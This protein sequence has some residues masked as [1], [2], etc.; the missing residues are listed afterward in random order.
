MTPRQGV[1]LL[2]VAVGAS[3]SPTS[4]LGENLRIQR[5]SWSVD[6][7][8]RDNPGDQSAVVFETTIEVPGAAWIR[9]WFGDVHL[10][11]GSVIVLTSQVDSS[12][13]V[14]D[15]V[16]V[17]Q[18]RGGSAY[19]NGESVCVELWAG[20]YTKGNSV[21]IDTVQARKLSGRGVESSQCGWTDDRWPSANSAIAR[22]LN[23][24]GSPCTAALVGA[25]G[26]LL[27]AGHCFA[28]PES[29]VVA[30]FNV[31]P[32]LPDGTLV[33]PPASEQYAIDPSSVQISDAGLGYDWAY[34][35]CF[36]NP[37]TGLTPA[38]AQ[39]SPL[40][41]AE[42]LPDVLPVTV[43]VTG[44]GIDTGTAN[45]TQQSDRG[46]LHDI[47]TSPVHLQYEVDT[48]A[49]NS[50]SPVTLECT[51]EVVGVHTHN[52]C[53]P[54][55]PPYNRG[56]PITEPALQ[57]AMATPL[58]VCADMLL[59]DFDGDGVPNDQDNCQLTPNGPD[60]GSCVAGSKGTCLADEDCDTRSG[61]GDGLCSLNQ[62]DSDQD[63]VGD[64]CDNCALFNPG[65][66]DCQPNG[67]GD[68]CDIADGT[69]SD[70]DGDCVPDECACAPVAD[71]DCDGDVDAFDLALLLGSWGPCPEPCEPGDPATT[72]PADLDGDCDV[73]AFDS[74]LL[75]GNWGP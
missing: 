57:A 59:E 55:P 18:W 34:F 24:D 20:P 38:Q 70:D 13:Q 69:S 67:I 8:P 14:L 11:P 64:A 25:A 39:G 7:G 15:A 12:Y 61:S 29:V 47:P 28:S 9:L 32:S 54:N 40:R 30:E 46:P 52:G 36:P 42:S 63:G 41:A 48:Q 4:A 73:G 10:G 53:V 27:S 68:V 74:A 3:L 65:Q 16:A 44:Y 51:A 2:I 17:G 72:C 37:V 56:T 31:P 23:V 19:F 66:L 35:G 1:L 62:E 6:S 43:V 45:S 75:L 33:H 60:L 50:G 26:C 49:G 21:T 71:L 22:I 58:G 5:I